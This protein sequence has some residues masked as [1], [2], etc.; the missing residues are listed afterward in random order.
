MNYRGATRRHQGLTLIYVIE[1]LGLVLDRG[2]L[3]LEALLF[4]VGDDP[5]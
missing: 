1:F 3:V 5:E 4:F 2:D